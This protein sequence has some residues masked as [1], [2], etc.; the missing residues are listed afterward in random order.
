MEISLPAE[1]LFSIGPFPVTN[2][3]LVTWGVMIVLIILA[4]SV[5]RKIKD[6]PSGFQNFVE[7][8]LELLFNLFDSVTQDRKLTKRFFPLV[9]TIFIFIIVANWTEILPGLGSIGL[10]HH[11]T[12]EEGAVN[13]QKEI[14]IIPFLRSPSS[15]LNFTLAIAIV[16]VIS[17]QILGI[18]SLGFFKYI[19]KFI[20]FRGPINFFV[21]ILEMV[22]EL[23]KLLSFSLRLFGNIFAGEVLLLVMAFL[24]P[25]IAPIPFYLLEIFVGFV[26]ALIFSMLTLVFATMAVKAGEH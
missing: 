6:V 5:K 25:L 7:W 14:S 26:Q 16:S 18:L 8:V 12:T 22:S 19:K 2:S 17:V 24:V 15:D 23:A 4:V 1:K 9:A 13:A 11:P 3:L 21:G 10:E 20:N